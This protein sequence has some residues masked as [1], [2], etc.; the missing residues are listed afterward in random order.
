V[1]DLTP[2]ITYKFKVR[3]RNAISPSQDS[4]IITALAA[5]VP[6]APLSASTYIEVNNVIVKWNA[7]TLNSLSTYGSE[8]QGYRVFIRWSDGTYG[9][10]LTH[11]DGS[12]PTIIADT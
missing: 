2:G 10:Q 3:S 5:I 8:I 4:N 12:N 6:N 7:P 1:I 11:C 9:E